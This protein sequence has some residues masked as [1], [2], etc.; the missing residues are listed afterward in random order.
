VSNAYTDLSVSIVADE[1]PRPGFT[2]TNTIVYSNLGSQSISG[3][4]SFVNDPIVAIT[5]N[6]QSGVVYN[7][8]GFS[9]NFTN[10]LPFETRE[11]TVTMQVPL[12]PIVEL[13]DLLTNTANIVPLAGDVAVENNSSESTQEIIGSYDPNDK[14]ESRGSEI[15]IT[16]FTNAD[17]LYY[18]IR[19]ENTGTASAINVNISD[20][21]HAGLDAASI[22]MVGAS[23]EYV[24]DRVDNQ[25]NWNF[26][27][28]MLPA[29]IDNPEGAKGFV[30]FKV[31]PLPG[32]QV[33]DNISNT[34]SIFF[35]FNP[36]IVTNTFVSTFVQ[37]LGTEDLS[38]AHFNVYPNPAKEQLYI[39]AN[40][41]I[42]KVT[43][44]DLLGKTIKSTMV[45][46][47]STTV[48]VSE[49]ASGL[50]LVEISNGSSR[51]ISKLIIE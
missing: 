6:S 49:M 28:I 1:S 24:L 17:Y 43:I 51:N 9:Y 39:D 25:L 18:T 26:S 31:K 11:I 16:E 33:G 34:A 50:Y 3:T 32:Y 38:V 13:G 22:R 27:N 42:D 35:D 15:L 4:V 14:T 5:A 47:T 41:N 20:V 45:N 2:Y 36:A 7:S 10:L 29:A 30:H 46:G 19:F 44:Y 40:T 23:H 8:N 12:I 48:D 37:Q 21:L